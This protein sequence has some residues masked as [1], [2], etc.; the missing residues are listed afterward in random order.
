VRAPV[1][2][3]GAGVRLAHAELAKMVA[4]AGNGRLT[5]ASKSVH[6]IVGDYLARCDLEGRSPTTL[7]EYHR[8]AD[9]V[10][11]PQL[12]NLRAN[13]RAIPTASSTT[14]LAQK[15][16]A[17]VWSSPSGCPPCRSR[18]WSPSVTGGLRAAS[19]RDRC[20]RCGIFRSFAA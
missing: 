15:Q 11:G 9:K 5:A 16:L 3:P 13:K 2:K 8:L 19:E 10:V 6:E 4:K 12:G 18:S 17:G 1:A 7:G 20:P 14:G